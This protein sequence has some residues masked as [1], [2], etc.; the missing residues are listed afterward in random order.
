[1]KG[2]SMSL[3]DIAAAIGRSENTV[4]SWVRH[5]LPAERIGRIWRINLGDL[6]SWREEQAGSAGDD[7]LERSKQIR[8]AADARTAVANAKVAER[9]EKVQSG[10]FGKISVVFE[11]VNDMVIGFRSHLLAVPTKISPQLAAESNPRKIFIA[12]T[13]AIHQAMREM[14]EHCESENEKATAREMR[15]IKAREAKAKSSTTKGE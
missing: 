15:A 2:T 11:H 1:M 8:A 6:L 12:L 10:E 5:G 9:A 3:T 14:T 4:R 13:D 7:S